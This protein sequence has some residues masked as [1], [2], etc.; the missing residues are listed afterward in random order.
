MSKLIEALTREHAWLVAMLGEVQKLRIG[1]EAS[2]KVLF[3]AK[4]GLLVHLGKE[5]EQLYPVLRRAAAADPRLKRTLEIFAEELE[6][7][8]AGA[9][10]FFEKYDSGD[11]SNLDFAVDLGQLIGTLSQRIQKEESILYVEYDKLF[12]KP[13]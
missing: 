1:T 7:V 12:Q 4:N 9:L 13:F 10:R 11:T 8:A 6:Q 5:N 3:E 2:N